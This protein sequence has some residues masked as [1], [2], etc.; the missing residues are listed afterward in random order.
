MSKPS[1]LV[2]AGCSWVVGKNVDVIESFAYQL[3]QQLKLDEFCSVARNGAS[4][5]EQI[6]KLVDFIAS[7]KDRY[8]Y[9][10]VLIGLTSLFRWDMYSSVTG[11][12]ESCAVGRGIGPLKQEIKHY[13]SHYFNEKY[14]LEKLNTQ[15]IMLNGYLKSL[16]INHLFVNSFQSYQFDN[17]NEQEFY[18]VKEKNNDMLSFL[19]KTNGIKISTSSVPFL[20]LLSPNAQF[21][22]YSIKE[23]Q[24]KGWLDVE[25]AHPTVQA[26]KLIANELYDYI[27]DKK[28]E[29]I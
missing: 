21:N 4:N 7:N 15:V 28:D 27:K 18:R 17:I 29:R 2:A 11:K 24:E 23:L 14:E 16:N 19:C 22:N 9:I 5:T 1:V 12:V 25:T 10:F 6:N 26:H 20:N 8:S 13:F 3:Q